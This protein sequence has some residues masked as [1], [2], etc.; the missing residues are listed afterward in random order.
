MGSEMPNVL[1]VFGDQWRAQATG[2]AGDP[3]V[4]TPNIDALAAESI[5]FTNAVM[6]CPVCS[7]ARACMVTGRYPL[8]HGVFMNDLYLKH[9]AVSIADAFGGAG[10]D[11]AYIGKWHLDG[12]GRST[13]IPQERRQGFGFWRAMECTHD[14][15]ES[16]YYADGPSR[17]QWDGYDA[18]AQTEEARRYLEEHGSERPF[19]LFLSWGPPHSP[20][21][22]APEEYRAMYQPDSL[23]LRPNVP[24]ECETLARERLAGYYAH[25]TAMDYCIGVLD[26]TLKANDLDRDTILVFTSD[27]GDMLGSHGCWGKQVPYDES[28]LA[29]FLL[30]YPAEFGT[31]A[32]RIDAPINTPDI[33]PTLLSL[34][35][36]EIPATVEGSD[37]TP[38]IRGEKDPGHVAA[39]IASYAPLGD[40]IKKKGAV[41]YR[42]VRTERYTYTRTLRG[43]WLLFDNEEDPCQMSNLCGQPACA[44]VQRRLERALG[45]RLKETNDAFLPSES[46]IKE[47]GIRVDETGT[48][49]YTD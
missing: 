11:T 41:E 49:P 15:N 28:I 18:I 38:F 35:G 46:L 45:Q 2:Y 17:L 4:R 47:Y 21:D 10:Y 7:P 27:H 9:K 8:G 26:Q 33:M 32:R 6:G 20:Y 3:N 31:K 39:L 37:Y 48:V 23:L 30:R 42:G 13:F 14:Y 24:P 12:H 29:P 16:C 1:Y 40:W 44:R 36:T 34:C 25:I 43:P 5:S 22:T 19:L